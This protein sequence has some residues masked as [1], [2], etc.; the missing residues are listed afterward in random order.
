MKS[1]WLRVQYRKPFVAVELTVPIGGGKK[2]TFRARIDTRHIVALL[3]R[4]GVEISGFLGK[5]WKGVKKVGKAIGI[6]KVVKLASK[7]LPAVAAILPPPA[8]AIAGGAALAFKAGTNLVKAVGHKRK[9]NKRKAAAIVRKTA[10][11]FKKAQKTLGKKK[12]RQAMQQ[13]ARLYQIQVKAL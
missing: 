12:A 8:N 1:P 9:G 5:L 13:G 4:H 2:Q 7:A 6:N 11:T 10:R 3:Q